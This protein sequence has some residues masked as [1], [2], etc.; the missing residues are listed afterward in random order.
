MTACCTHC[1]ETKPEAEFPANPRKKNG[2]S[3]W[4]RDCHNEARDRSYER[5]L[6]RLIAER[7]KERAEWMAEWR[8][9]MR[10]NR[11]T[12]AENRRRLEAK[13]R[14]AVA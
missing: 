11:E 10:R 12:M 9:N 5:K 2:L 7:Q 4:C 3:S 1:G 8:E 13:K 14:K 6:E